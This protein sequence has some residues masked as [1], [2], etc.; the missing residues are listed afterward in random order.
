[1]T[2]RDRLS[3]W[4]IIRQL[5]HMQRIVVGRF[6]KRNDASEHLKILQRLNPTAHYELMF[7]PMSDGYEQ[8]SS[9]LIEKP[10]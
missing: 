3:P 4:C 8:P 2:Y 5:P 10:Q 6:R 1:M 7:D 9:E